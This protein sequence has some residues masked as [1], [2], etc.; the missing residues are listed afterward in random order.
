MGLL[1]GVV[2]FLTFLLAFA[3]RS[4]GGSVAGYGLVLAGA[5]A[6]N[7]IGSFVAPHL[8]ELLREDQILLTALLCTAGIGLVGALVGGLGADVFVVVVIGVAGAAA[9]LAFDSLVQRDAP[10]SDTG[11]LLAQFEARFQMLWVVGAFIPVVVPLPARLGFLLLGLLAAAASLSDLLG[12][13]PLGAAL[14]Q[15]AR[16]GVQNPAQPGPPPRPA[17]PAGTRPAADR[18]SGAGNPRPTTSAEPGEGR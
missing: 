7:L 1:R 10:A 14:T 13:Q 5:G 3:L 9:K 16:R 15:L 4:G 8:R 2:G 17:P 18:A 6:G 12:R 11:R